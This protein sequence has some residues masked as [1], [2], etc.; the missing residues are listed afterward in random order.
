MTTHTITNAQ[1]LEKELVKI[2]QQGFAIDDREIMESLRCIAAP[3]YDRDG[4]VKYA[5]SVSVLAG[6]LIG[7]RLD[8][9]R[10]ALVRTAQSISF[11]MGYQEP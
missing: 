8:S 1:E 5:L 10:E 4:C 11:L 3:I 2:R 7:D 6:N 9:T